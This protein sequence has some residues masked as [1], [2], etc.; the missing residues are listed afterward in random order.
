MSPFRNIQRYL[1]VTMLG[2]LE[3]QKLRMKKTYSNF[4]F[5]CYFSNTPADSPFPLVPSNLDDHAG[6]LVLTRYVEMRARQPHLHVMG[7]ILKRPSISPD[8]SPNKRPCRQPC[9]W[10][11][12]CWR[13]SWTRRSP[14][15][16]ASLSPWWTRYDISHL[17]WKLQWN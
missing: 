8:S 10:R 5:I 14:W 9:T 1:S 3:V 12:W 6:G 11:R 17:T 13:Q 2:S 15:S 4:I 7:R 16:G